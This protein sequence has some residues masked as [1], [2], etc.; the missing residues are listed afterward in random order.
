MPL[1]KVKLSGRFPRLFSAKLSHIC[2]RKYNSTDINSTI[3]DEK[4]K[5]YLLQNKF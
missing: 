5:E 1:V 3:S 4:K 2:Q